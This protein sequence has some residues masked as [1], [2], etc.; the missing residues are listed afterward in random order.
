LTLKGLTQEPEAASV[1]AS[2]LT[3]Q[4]FIYKHITDS[5]NIQ[6]KNKNEKD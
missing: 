1:G 2:V 6:W 4:N 3:L 5:E